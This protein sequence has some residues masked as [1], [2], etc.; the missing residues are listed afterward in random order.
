MKSRFKLREADSIGEIKEDILQLKFP[1]LIDIK[2]S[3]H[4]YC[5]LFNHSRRSKI[6]ILH[7]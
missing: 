6:R 2:L 7:R 5:S 1:I 3:S 4:K